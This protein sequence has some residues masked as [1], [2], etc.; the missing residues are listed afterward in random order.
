M[1]SFGKWKEPPVAIVNL[2]KILKK[3]NVKGCPSHFSLTI[4]GPRSG[5]KLLNI[6]KVGTLHG[7][8]LQS[9][10]AQSTQPFC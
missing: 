1:Q 9:S 4:R 3:I 5:V 7:A 2:S 10:T 8:P 6:Y